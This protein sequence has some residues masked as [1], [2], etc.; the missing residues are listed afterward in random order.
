MEKIQEILSKIP[1]FDGLPGDQLESVRQIT[2]K[3]LFSKGDIIFSEGD[4]GK[5]FYVSITGQVK[6]FKISFEGKEKIIHIAQPGDPFG[7]VPVFAGQT[8][9]ANAAAISKCEIMF[10]PRD[11]FS[12][13]IAK[14][15]SLGLNMLAVLSKKLRL[16]TVQIENISLKEVPGRLASYLIYLT[17]EQG[18]AN[19][20]TLTISKGQLAGLLG[21]IPETM[22]RIFSKMTEQ[23]LIAVN[24]REID[25]IDMD[26]LNSLAG[27]GK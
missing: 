1:L 25:L 24:G 20:V 6:I 22:S 18:N 27:T 9:P 3:I 12:D 21:T 19:R 5:G 10:F 16:L 14:N 4:P 2:R 7:E 17:K 13:L 26:G 11:A 15:P 23:Q 8:F